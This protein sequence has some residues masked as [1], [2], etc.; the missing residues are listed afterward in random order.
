MQVCN[1]LKI[2]GFPTISVLDGERVYDYQGKLTVGDLSKFI[3]DKEYLEK[4]RPRRISH[5]TS[6]WENLVNALAETKQKMLT[7]T[8]LLFQVVGLGHLDEPFVV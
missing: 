5:L 8:M 4:S 2:R 6:P 3:S 7:F 1:R